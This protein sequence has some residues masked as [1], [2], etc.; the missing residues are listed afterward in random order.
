MSVPVDEEV[1]GQ[2]STS[3]KRERERQREAERERG[4]ERERKG[5]R[6]RGG[7]ERERERER[8]SSC[9]DRG[10][11][12]HPPKSLRE[13]F[14]TEAFGVFLGKRYRQGAKGFP[15]RGCIKCPKIGKV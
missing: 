5:E 11:K 8:E 9:C 12:K 7:G 14:L 15:Q 4:R 2:S 13:V 6:E 1:L 3:G 10:V